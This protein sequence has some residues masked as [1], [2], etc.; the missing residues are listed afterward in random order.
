MTPRL[1]F[2][3]FW[4][5]FTF[6]GL[7]QCQ[8]LYV[9]TM[10]QPTSAGTMNDPMDLVTAFNTAPNG[11]Y[12]R[13]ATGTYVISSSLTLNGQQIVVEGGFIDT[14][15]WTKTSL[16]GAT[17]I[18]RDNTNLSGP[19]TVPRLTAIEL[20]SKSG[21]RFQDITFQT[22]S[23]SA[24]SQAQP[25]GVSVYGV[26]MD[27]CSSYSFVRC[28][29]LAGPASAGLSGVNGAAGANG[30]NGTTGS[31]GS[32]DG[33]TCT[34][35]SGNAGAAG[36]QG[37]QGATGVS[38]GGGGA[39][40]T[41]QTNPGAN[42]NTGTG[43]NGGSGGG[44]GAGGDECSSN[45]GGNGGNGGSSACTTGGSGGVKGNDGDPGGNGTNGGNGTAG[46]SGALGTPGLPGGDLAGFWAPGGPGGSGLDGCGGSGGGGGGGGGR[47]VCTFCDNGPGN[48]GSGGGGGGQ[49]GSGG[50]GGYG[51]GGS[52]AI[53]INYNGS[54]GQLVDCYLQSGAG[55]QGGQGGQGGTGGLGG[56]GG[57]VQ[58]ACS[59]EIGDG[60]AGGSGGNGGSGGS[61]GSGAN[62]ISETLRVVSGDTLLMANDSF[63]LQGQPEI[64]VSYAYCSNANL[65]AEAMGASNVV[66]SI[67]TPTATSTSNTNPTSFVS[68][69]TGYTSLSAQVDLFTNTSYTDFI[70]IG[71]A[72]Q[73]TGFTETIC[74]GGS[75]LF[76]N[77]T[78]TQAGNYTATYSN[79]QGCDSIVVMTLVVDAINNTVSIN[80]SNGQELLSSNTGSV[81]Y[82]WLNCT[83]GA[84]LPGAN[85]ASLLVTQNGTYAVISNNANGCSDTSNCVT[86][87]YIGLD[88]ASSAPFS[89]FP[90]PV[91]SD[92]TLQF[93]AP[94][95]GSVYI[96][97]MAGKRIYFK[98]VEGVT[99]VSAMLEAPQG[100][101]L[102]HAADEFGVETVRVVKR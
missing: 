82:Q 95:T 74:Q 92:I 89:V 38:G 52:F 98:E 33:G 100:V 2:A 84:M 91:V 54:N 76:N 3:F 8:V 43:R 62:G 101:Y 40:N 9:S 22:Q 12:I 39:A 41:G 6:S 19:N 68:G 48:G 79:V 4:L 34:F 27:S 1:L 26:Y 73:T 23:A 31:A 16:A 10:G 46:A 87:N 66:W 29:V 25:Y 81:S 15:A 44:G 56:S 11:S 78:C 18:Y 63:D 61:G 53:Y 72:S 5:F 55:G 49:G 75:V 64:Q 21:I 14:M 86:I 94:F 70:Y 99:T 35:S 42:G 80:P 59:N 67:N 24:P 28:Q 37:G 13:V 93:A 51:G 71:C 102:V 47:Q 97:D 20:F 7:S 36:G 69:S 30:G 88:E 77:Q 85:G 83:T 32:C 17:T 58:A 90:N 60:G 57:G 96:T 65:Q 50:Y 45:N